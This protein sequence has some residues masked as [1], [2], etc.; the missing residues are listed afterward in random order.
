MCQ[1]CIHIGLVDRSIACH[2]LQIW[3]NKQIK[4]LTV[5]ML[6]ATRT[7]AHA[8]VTLSQQHRSGFATTQLSFMPPRKQQAGTQSCMRD[9]LAKYKCQSPMQDPHELHCLHT[10]W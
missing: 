6:S 1:R 10:A 5:Y 7:H 4:K 8:L 9:N 2:G 3:S